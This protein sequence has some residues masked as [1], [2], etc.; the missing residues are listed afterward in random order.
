MR[1]F[2]FIAV[3]DSTVSTS[4]DRVILMLV[5]ICVVSIL[6]ILGVVHIYITLN[7][8]LS[9]CAPFLLGIPLKVTWQCLQICIFSIF[10]DNVAQSP[11]VILPINAP[12]SSVQE[13]Q[14]L[15]I[16]INNWYY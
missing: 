15:R 14:L 4:N 2:V 8:C 1:A 13:F 10:L 12:I 7:M 16:L 5:C 6:E 11:R 3:L 9:L